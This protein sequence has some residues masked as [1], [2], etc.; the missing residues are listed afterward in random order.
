MLPLGDVLS[1]HVDV[2]R[3]TDR[4]EGQREDLVVEWFL[5]LHSI[6]GFEN[7]CDAF[8]QL[9]RNL[10]ADLTLPLA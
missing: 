8:F 7:I 2:A 6:V 4:G 3:V 1:V 5:D 9:L 10:I